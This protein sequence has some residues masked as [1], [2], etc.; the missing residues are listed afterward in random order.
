MH[1]GEGGA[2]EVVQV[3]RRPSS[4]QPGLHAARAAR[5]PRA[6]GRHV[7]ARR[8]RGERAPLDQLADQ[9]VR[10][11]HR[12]PARSRELR[13]A[14]AAGGPRRT[15][16]AA[17]ARA[18]VTLAPGVEVLP[19]MGQSSH[20]DFR[21]VEAQYASTARRRPTVLLVTRAAACHPGRHHRGDRARSPEHHE[22]RRASRR[23]QSALDYPPYRCSLL[24]HPTKDPHQADPE[25]VELW[26]R[27][28]A[29]ATSV[30]LEADLTIQHGG[31][32][33]GERIV[34]TGRV[35]DGDG[36]PVRRQLV[37]IW[38][39]NAGGRYI[40]Q[41]D[42]HPA[43]L[44]PNFTGVG[45]LPHRRRR[46]ATAFT[47][48]KPGPTRGEPPQR[49][50]AGAH[51]LLAVRHRVHPAAGHPDVL[52]GR[53]AVRARPDLPVDRRPA[54]PRAA[55]GDVRPRRHRAR[56]VHRLPLGHRAHR[57]PPHPDRG[58]RSDA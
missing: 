11:R 47:T 37:E 58:G 57:R 2:V 36:R 15:R 32:P 1:G 35:L 33:I 17:P 7:L 44:D 48:I 18:T 52:P 24:R 22:T 27:S 10:G 3:R 21:P 56:V 5:G 14:R 16:R 43:P 30:P 39:A 29:S 34:V 54:G 50:A 45:P 25:G 28:S 42:Q 38:Q 12:Q 26:A 53:P 20:G 55:G 13:S 19:A 23:P 9:P 31:E 51:P 49:L 4:T 46:R 41:R 8:R 40:H 6:A